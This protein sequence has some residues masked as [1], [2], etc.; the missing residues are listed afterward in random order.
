[1][2]EFTDFLGQKMQICGVKIVEILEVFQGQKN[3][4]FREFSRKNLLSF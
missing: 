3:R 2:R 4:E 1:M